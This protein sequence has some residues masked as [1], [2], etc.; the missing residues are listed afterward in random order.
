MTAFCSYTGTE[1]RTPL[2]YC[3][4]YD[5]LSNAVPHTQQV[6]TQLVDVIYAFL[7]DLQLHYS[8]DVIIIIKGVHIWAVWGPLVGRNEVWH[9]SAWKCDCV[10]CPVRRCTVLLE[11]EIAVQPGVKVNG[12]YYREL[13]LKEKL[14]PCIKKISG[15]NFIFQQDSKPA[16]RARWIS[17][18]RDSPP[19]FQVSQ[20]SVA[21]DLRWGKNFNK[22]IFQTD[23]PTDRQT[24]AQ[25]DRWARRQVYTI[26][27]NALHLF[28]II[29]CTLHKDGKFCRLL[30]KLGDAWV[31]I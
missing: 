23:R 11:Y 8:P 18:V 25:T 10:T 26:S 9:I 13:L 12:D 17:G 19:T 30:I 24:Q 29:N 27:A 6:L 2:I 4:V 1:S 21:T 31:S 20:G 7:I 16:H 14:L 5:V 3:F 28:H 22:F 15:D